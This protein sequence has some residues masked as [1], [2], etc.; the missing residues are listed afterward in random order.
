MEQK[1]SQTAESSGAQQVFRILGII[2]LSSVILKVGSPLFIPLSFALLISFILQPVCS[3]LEQKGFGRV[4]A[5]I[6]GLLVLTVLIGVLIYLLY[7]QFR[8]FAQEW[9]FLSGKLKE[10]VFAFKTYLISDMGFEKA[11][12]EKWFSDFISSTAKNTVEMIETS[13]VSVFVN[14]VMIFLIPI[15]AFLIMYYRQLLVEVLYSLFPVGYRFKIA[16]VI[17]LSIKTYYSF[18]KGMAVVYFIVGILNSV[19]LL[20]LGVPH[21]FLFGFLCA[22][23]TFIPY[24]GIIIASALPITYAWITYSSIWYPV[25]VIAIFAF[26][27]YLEANII[28]PWAVSQKLQLNTLVTL[29]II[30]AGGI[31]WGASG[32]ILFI[33]FA[34]V[35]KLIAD[36]MEG[37][38]SLS[39]FLG[40]G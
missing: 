19:G 12:V 4:L 24:V 20:L 6:T 11:Q 17:G 26:V 27:Q 29:A 5:I 38:A 9:S 13:L 15:Y 2:V 21:A 25:G 1:L 18:I 28:F 30:V 34:G 32:M 16:E 22:I 14:I 33:P 35:L 8:N 23:M 37:W 7:V 3:F 10:L 36:R 40:K 31:L 39:R